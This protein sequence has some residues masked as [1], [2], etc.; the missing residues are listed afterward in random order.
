MFQHNW[1]QTPNSLELQT[2]DT[3]K[4]TLLLDLAKVYKLVV[5]LACC[6][7]ASRLPDFTGVDANGLFKWV[8]DVRLK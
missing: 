3:E 8:I 1:L 5:L 7:L 2:T 4:S 6:N